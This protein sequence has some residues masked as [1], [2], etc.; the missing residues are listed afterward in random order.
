MAED[1]F[2]WDSEGVE[3]PTVE[4]HTKARHRITEEYARNWIATLGGNNRGNS[5]KVTIIDGFCG[6]G[7]YTDPDNGELWGGSPIRLI[8]AIERGLEDIKMDKKKPNFQLDAKFIFIDKKQS[9]LNC[10]KKY[11]TSQG[12][13]R[14][15]E[16]SNRYEYVCSEFEQVSEKLLHLVNSRGG[17]SLFILDPTGYSHVSMGTIRKIIN[18]GRSEILYTFMIEYIERFLKKRKGDLSHAINNILEAE[19]F[20]ENIHA[21]WQS[22][23]Q[24]QSY[25]KDEVLRLF[26]SQGGAPFVFCFGLLPKSL[27]VKYFLVHLASSPSAERELKFSLW[28]H[29]NQLFLSQFALDVFGLCFRTPDFYDINPSLFDIKE[30]NARQSVDYLTNQL[31][32]KIRRSNEGVTF[33]NLHDS[34]VQYTPSTFEHY[35]QF[36]N[37]QRDYGEIEVF[38]NGKPTFAKHIEPGDIISNPRMG[39]LFDLKPYIQ[40]Q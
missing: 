40:R 5:K 16:D 19:G 31:I 14:S 23:M 11:L 21:T 10:L 33:Q 24:K 20:F 39:T 12:Y 30:V 7:V 13:G 18:I 17:S 38:R 37:E 8:Q 4:P 27:R 32:P 3:L 35:T 28:E 34:T 36:V 9:H 25:I 26:R 22:S 2:S 1:K 29:N 6:G 15:N